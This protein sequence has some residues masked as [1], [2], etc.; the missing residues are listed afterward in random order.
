M[1]R[2]SIM[3]GW[4]V[5][6]HFV[7]SKKFMEIFNMLQEAAER[8]QVNLIKKTN[9]ELMCGL[10]DYDNISIFEKPSFILFWD[11]DIRLAN[12]LEEKGF[13]LFNTASAIEICD[14]K[15]LSHIKLSQQGIKTPKTIVSPK[16]YWDVDY[17]KEEYIDMVIETLGFPLIVK[18]CFGSF[19]RQVYLVQNKDEL[20]ELLK[21]L[22]VRPIL[23]QEFIE[24]S[25]GRDV[26]IHI[27]G[28][29]M[30]TS[31]YRYNDND[32]RANITNGG[33]MKEYT[34]T[35]AQIELAVKV[36]DALGLDFAGVDILFGENDEPVFCEVNS[37]AHFKNIYDCTGVNVA[38]YI[39]RH[40]IDEINGFNLNMKLYA[41]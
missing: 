22:G 17:E 18:E 9:V 23:F 12:F 32:F 26:R 29:K 16:I 34:P 2:R 36:C 31:M 13:R 33:K 37:N 27:V 21:S 24:S 39:I 4:L 20:I 19:G 10:F 5:V 11:K 38:D 15:S 14:D 40:I 7:K 6:N 1:L 28:G 3:T 41:N 25:K 30:V 35:D 8:Q